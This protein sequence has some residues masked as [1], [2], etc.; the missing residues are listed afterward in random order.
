MKALPM[1]SVGPS[2]ICPGFRGHLLW[3]QR[4]LHGEV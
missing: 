4:G 2:R 1:T 3:Q